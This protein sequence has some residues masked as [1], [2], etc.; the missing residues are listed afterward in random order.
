MWNRRPLAWAFIVAL[1]CSVLLMLLDLL[2]PQ[3]LR[4]SPDLS[5]AGAVG[6]LAGPALVG[7]GP[8]PGDS[9]ALHAVA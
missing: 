3:G 7:L 4:V 8:H 9:L 5:V 2:T 6:G 1:L